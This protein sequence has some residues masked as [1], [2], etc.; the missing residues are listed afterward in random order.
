[1]LVGGAVGWTI[2]QKDYQEQRLNDLK[3]Q[4]VGIDANQKQQLTVL[5]EIRNALEEVG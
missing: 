3:T 2:Y 5:G 4:L 1:M